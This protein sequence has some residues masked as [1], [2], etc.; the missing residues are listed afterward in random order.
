M[1]F[2]TFK[3]TDADSLPAIPEIV[4]DF[5]QVMGKKKGKRTFETSGRANAL[6]TE[7]SEQTFVDG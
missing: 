3:T 1:L 4:H 7:V 2:S 6:K 5:R